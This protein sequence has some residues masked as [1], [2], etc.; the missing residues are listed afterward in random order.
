MLKNDIEVKSVRQLRICH[1]IRY[2]NLKDQHPDLFMRHWIFLTNL[3]KGGRIFVDTGANCNTISDKFYR[4]LLDQGL[5]CAF[6]P[7][8]GKGIDIN[9]VGGQRLN[10]SGDRL[11]PSVLKS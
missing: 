3:G 7:G 4:A 8:S 1:Q 10:S 5:K 11:L 2:S 9:F 6:Y